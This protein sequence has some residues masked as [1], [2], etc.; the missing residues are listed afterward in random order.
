MT[1]AKYGPR[2]TIVELA[3]AGSG[4]EILA[5]LGPIEASAYV[6]AC[7]G[8][9]AVAT[10]RKTT[11]LSVLDVFEKARDLRLN[12]PGWLYQALQRHPVIYDSRMRHGRAFRRL[13]SRVL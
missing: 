7:I 6:G 5:F 10:L 12:P 1:I 13:A 11:G 2:V 3:I 4:L 8:S 9:I